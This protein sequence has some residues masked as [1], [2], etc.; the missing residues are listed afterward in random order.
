MLFVGLRVELKLYI[1]F[2]LWFKKFKENALPLID[3]ALYTLG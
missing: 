1:H 3:F 2:V